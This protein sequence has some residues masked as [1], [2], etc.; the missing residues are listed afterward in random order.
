MAAIIL[1]CIGTIIF[2]L[3]Y[4]PSKRRFILPDK[5]VTVQS[6][7]ELD[8]IWQ[9]SGV[10]GRIAVIFTRHLNNQ[11]SGGSFPEIDYLDTA[12]RQGIVRRAYFIVPDRI[13]FVGATKNNLERAS[14][15]PLKPNDSGFTLL[16]EGGR[17]QIMP[18]SKYIPEQESEKV[19]VVIEPDVWSQQELF[20]INNYFRSGQLTSDLVVRIG[21]AAALR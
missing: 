7:R 4:G 6:A 9:S 2:T 17:I 14:I 8:S 13:W 1:F 21:A 15:V 16:H 3:A 12:M 19:L 10:H 5:L 18:L 11:F 20:K